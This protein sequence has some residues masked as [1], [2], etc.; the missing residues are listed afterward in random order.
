MQP[1]C[2]KGLV[3]CGT[4][5]GDMQLKDRSSRIIRKSRVLYSGSGFLSSAT[6]PSIPKKHYNVLKDKYPNFEVG[7]KY[8]I[9]VF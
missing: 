1:D 2:L 7:L 9:M 8:I 5:Y 3:V 4:V 6:W